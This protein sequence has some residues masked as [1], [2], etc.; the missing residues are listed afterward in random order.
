MLTSGVLKA[1]VV[2]ALVLLASCATA[3]APARNPF[4]AQP[5]SGPVDVGSGPVGKPPDAAE[6]ERAMR[7]ARAERAASRPAPLPSIEHRDAELRAAIEALSKDESAAAHVRVAEAYE[8]VHVRDAAFDQFSAAIALDKK[9]VAAWDGRAR[10]WRDWGMVEQAL[11]DV[12]R[13]RYY[14]PDRPEVLN[15]LGTILERVGECGA[16]RAAYEQALKLAPSAP[17]AKENV[18]RMAVVAPDCRPKPGT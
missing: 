10:L 15:T 3:P 11:H 18:G 14:G 5:G 6:V 12:Y 4:I 1:A 8:R 9:S 17:W 13:A 2:P 7:K 16:A